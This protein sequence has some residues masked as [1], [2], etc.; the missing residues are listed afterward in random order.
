MDKKHVIISS[1]EKGSVDYSQVLEDSENTVRESLSG[2][3]LLIRYFGP[4]PESVLNLSSKS[5]EYNRE[6]I[7]DILSSEDWTAAEEDEDMI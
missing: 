4:A 7:L 3:L 6:E 5:Q 1:S 2:D